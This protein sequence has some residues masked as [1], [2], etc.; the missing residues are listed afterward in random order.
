MSQDKGK[1]C[2]RFV[3][4]LPRSCRSRLKNHLIF[5]SNP[6]VSIHISPFYSKLDGK[7]LEGFEQYLVRL[8]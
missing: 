8:N 5:Y 7:L 4:Y 6:K 1:A 3:T 2:E